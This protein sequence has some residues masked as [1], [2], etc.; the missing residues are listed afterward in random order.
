[1][2][3]PSKRQHARLAFY[4]CVLLALILL[5]AKSPPALALPPRPEPTPESPPVVGGGIELRIYT[6]QADTSQVVDWESVQTLVQWQDGLGGWHD[7]DGW[8]GTLDKIYAD[9]GHKTWFVSE[10]HFDTGPFRW[11]IYPGAKTPDAETLATSD[12]FNMPSS[13]NETVRI[14]VTIP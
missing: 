9:G 12:P 5:F 14:V 10:A 1:M 2:K 3:M 11:V 4:G 6:T 8:R 13:D 7:V